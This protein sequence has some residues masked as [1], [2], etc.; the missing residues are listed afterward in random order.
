MTIPGMITR[1]MNRRFPESGF[2]IS[3]GGSALFMRGSG[4]SYRAQDFGVTNDIYL[5]GQLGV[6]RYPLSGRPWSR[7]WGWDDRYLYA[8]RPS[9]GYRFNSRIA[10][11]RELRLLCR[12]NRQQAWV[13]CLLQQRKHQPRLSIS[14][15]RCSFLPASFCRTAASSFLVALKWCL[16]KPPLITMLPLLARFL[17]CVPQEKR[18]PPGFCL[19]PAVE[20]AIA[21]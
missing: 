16:W 3:A 9:I 4:T 19:A 11:A 13:W 8:L 5:E 7:A 14:N 21:R 17:L 10:V 6:W 18:K 2:F 15:S 20:L 1:M 12:K